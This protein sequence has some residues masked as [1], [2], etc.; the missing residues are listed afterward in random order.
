MGL[1]NSLKW[2]I[3]KGKDPSLDEAIEKMFIPYKIKFNMFVVNMDC[4]S[5]GNSYSY[6][7][8]MKCSQKM[9][10]FVDIPTYDLP[11]GFPYWFYWAFP[12]IAYWIIERNGI[13][14]IKEKIPELEEMS[15]DEMNDP[16]TGRMRVPVLKKLVD[17]YLNNI[18][19]KL[20][21]GG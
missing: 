14:T 10:Y 9:V 8:G 13:Q 2:N 12:D 15:H 16:S 1:L 20:E 17:C 19:N 3:V 18:S 11:L 6:K 7:Y 4:F 21:I 5:T